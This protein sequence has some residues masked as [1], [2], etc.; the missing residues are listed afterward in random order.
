[1]AVPARPNFLANFLALET[2]TGAKGEDHRAA[3]RSGID[4]D[5]ERALVTAIRAD[6]ESLPPFGVTIVALEGLMVQP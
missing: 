2:A 1:M 6:A 3:A 5:F 4:P